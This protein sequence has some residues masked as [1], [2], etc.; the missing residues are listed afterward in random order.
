MT[1]IYGHYMPHDCRNAGGRKDV[2]LMIV[3]AQEVKLR[4]S[5]AEPMRMKL[6]ESIAS[7]WR[8]K[9]WSCFTDIDRS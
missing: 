1:T 7:G 8:D 5:S 3:V 9:D 2:K 6:E 4:W